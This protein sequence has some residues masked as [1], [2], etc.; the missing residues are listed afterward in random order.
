MK[1]KET[2]DE[3]DL[4]D[5]F[6][7]IWKK[8]LTVSLFI[9]FSIIITFTTQTNQSPS[10]EVATTE[11]REISVYDETKYKIY[12]LFI[13]TITPSYMK[14]GAD[15]SNKD[16]TG[17][18]KQGN[19]ER[20]FT[21]PNRIEENLVI[22]N[23]KKEFLFRLFTDLIQDKSYL[24]DLL[25]KFQFIKE[26][27]YSNMYEYNK[28]INKIANSI[29]LLNL[30]VQDLENN[31]T[32]IVI[33]F[34]SID[35][36]KWEIFLEYLEKQTNLRIQ[37]KLSD[38]LESYINYVNALK[39]FKI[40]DLNSQL[41]AVNLKE[42][43]RVDIERTREFLQN[44]KYVDQL[45]DIFSTSPLSNAEDFYAAKILINST[46]YKLADER[47]SKFIV[48][49]IAS[50]LGAIIGIFFVLLANAIQNRR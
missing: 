9:I 17:M 11:I 43:Q 27:D 47:S 34:V 5:T 7:I 45:K 36:K 1:K 10:K 41:E 42:E 8:K 3:I 39:K 46:K 18:V 40:N 14:K 33:K 20:Y 6:L 23:I 37:K 30:E 12:N 28:A 4:V 13:N 32:P 16:E 19:Q 49:I 15:L 26:E 38:M 25:K 50:L 35:V 2:I 22:N 48:F 24:Q 21:V 44:D 31:S 29:D